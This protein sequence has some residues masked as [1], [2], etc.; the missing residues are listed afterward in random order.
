MSFLDSPYK[1]HDGCFSR[2]LKFGISPDVKVPGTFGVETFALV[3]L[4]PETNIRYWSCC[5]HLATSLPGRK[6]IFFI[7]R[8]FMWHG[9]KKNQNRHPVIKS[10]LCPSESSIQSLWPSSV[11][12]RTRHDLQNKWTW[13]NTQNQRNLFST[14][15]E[16]Q[17]RCP[18]E[19]TR[20]LNMDLSKRAFLTWLTGRQFTWL[21][22]SWSE[23]KDASACSRL[24]NPRLNNDQAL[25]VCP[26]HSI[27]HRWVPLF[28]ILFIL[29]WINGSTLGLW[30]F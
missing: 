24:L 9:M 4:Y 28:P 13:K 27:S 1:Y 7:L 2:D 16:C 10:W 12:A 11:C 3:S 20:E 19:H 25:G 26:G 15:H 29:S 21:D 6:T 17:L 30:S 18:S 22:G 8:F 14:S 23:G 5:G